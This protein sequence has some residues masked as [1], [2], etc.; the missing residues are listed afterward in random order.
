MCAACAA[1]AGR[2][3]RQQFEA[4]EECL[5]LPFPF[6]L[7]K[8]RQS[9]G[10]RGGRRGAV[11][12][13]GMWG[14]GGPHRSLVNGFANQ[15]LGR[16][17]KCGGGKLEIFELRTVQIADR[18]R[19]LRCQSCHDPVNPFARVIFSTLDPREKI[20]QRRNNERA[21]R[22]SE[23]TAPGENRAQAARGARAQASS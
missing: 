9:R 14:R 16:P 23:S 13:G 11:Y 4:S 3:A 5:V 15:P 2:E 18:V 22:P 1:C 19:V 7:E 12:R 8:S 6:L 10:G 17:R 20:T 21:A